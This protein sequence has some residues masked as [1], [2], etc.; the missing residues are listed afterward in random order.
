M[1]K[2]GRS[3]NNNLK[4]EIWTDEDD[5]LLAEAVLKS[6]RH[7][8]T[9]IQACHE[10]EEKTDGRRTSSASKYRWF[11]KLVDQYKAAYDM[12]KKEGDKIKAVKKKKI[13]KGERYE[14]IMKEV[15]N[16]ENPSPVREITPDD[17]ILLVKKFKSQE[18]TKGKDTD[19]LEKEL[20][21]EKRKSS[22]LQ[23]KLKKK[24]EESAELE[25]MLKIQKRNYDKLLESLQVLKNA[26]IQI[27]IPEP[28][29]ESFKVNRDGTVEKM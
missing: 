13:N 17:I 22:D 25:E 26:G 2:D 19:K 7:G 23:K 18:E 29:K 3:Q 21:F 8:G 10:I 9:V 14:D 5:I 16:D 12:A 24:E 11:T 27:N 28:E 1:V 4:G 15:F 6:V 20:N